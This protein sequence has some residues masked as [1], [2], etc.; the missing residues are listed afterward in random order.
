MRWLLHGDP[1]GLSGA[2]GRRYGGSPTVIV[3]RTGTDG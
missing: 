1:G 2:G 3:F